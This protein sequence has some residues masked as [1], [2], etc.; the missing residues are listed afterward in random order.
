[1]RSVIFGMIAV[2][3]MPSL[4]EA[5]VLELLVDPITKQS[6]DCRYD[7]CRGNNLYYMK[8]WTKK[9]YYRYRIRRTAPHYAFR[10]ERVMVTPPEVLMLERTGKY[11]WRHGHL[12]VGATAKRHRVVRPAQYAWVTRRVLVRPG[13][14]RVYRKAPYR[15]YIPETI[16]VRGAGACAHACW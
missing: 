14:S 16:V 9:P 4:A 3:I 5:G 2:L 6:R 11:H 7:P 10:R 8:R 13:K 15:A 12:M 1:M